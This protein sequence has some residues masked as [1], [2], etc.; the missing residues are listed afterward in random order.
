MEQL[1]RA[2][3]L[4]FWKCITVVGEMFAM[5]L[6]FLALKQMSRVTNWDI[7]GT[8]IMVAVGSFQGLYESCKNNLSF[9]LSMLCKLC[10]QYTSSHSHII[11]N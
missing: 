6:I 3:H 9:E 8:L 11:I 1:L 2:I 5:I 4:V 7:V 10:L